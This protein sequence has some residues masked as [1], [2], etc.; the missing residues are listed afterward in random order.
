MGALLG[1][2]FNHKQ[3]SAVR[4]AARYQL[5]AFGQ[6][7]RT[8]NRSVR[9]NGFLDALMD[10]NIAKDYIREEWVGAGFGYL[11]HQEG[12]IYGKNTARV[13]LKYRSSKMWGIQPEFNYSFKDNNG[14]VG[15][16]VYFSL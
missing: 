13:F 7:D 10:V 14:F 16:G 1:M 8:N 11:I 15:L 6:T 3:N 5:K 2:N 12:H 9:Y 4:I